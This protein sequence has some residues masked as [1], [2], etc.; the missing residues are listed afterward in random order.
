MDDLDMSRQVQAMEAYQ[1]MK[2]LPRENECGLEADM[3]FHTWVC[4]RT[5]NTYGDLLRAAQSYG[6]PV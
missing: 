6:Y 1:F 4:L 2:C 5:D 3:L